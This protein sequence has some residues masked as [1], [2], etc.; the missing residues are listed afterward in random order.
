MTADSGNCTIDVSGS[1]YGASGTVGPD[2]LTAIDQAE[3][4]GTPIFVPIYVSVTSAGT[5]TL[6]G[7][8]AFVITGYNLAGVS[9]SD[10][11]NPLNDC[12]GSDSC[13]NGYFT[14]AVM[15]FTGSLGGTNLGASVINLTG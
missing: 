13:L 14:Q 3:N 9:H 7:F 2:C 10:W 5:Y 15:P 12:Q 6:K 1:R 8:A 11:L 4:N